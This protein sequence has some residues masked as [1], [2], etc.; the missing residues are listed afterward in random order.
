MQLGGKQHNVRASRPRRPRLDDLRVGPIAHDVVEP[1]WRHRLAPDQVLGRRWRDDGTYP[2]VAS[3]T[4][5]NDAL[6]TVVDDLLVW[7]HDA[8]DSLDPKAPADV[9]AQLDAYVRRRLARDQPMFVPAF[10]SS[11]F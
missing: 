11:A 7:L 9:V 10:T 2:T 6:R 4:E 3:L 5:E 8:D 1:L